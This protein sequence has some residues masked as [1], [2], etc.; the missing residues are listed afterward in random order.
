M[1]L[2]WEGFRTR[3]ADVGCAENLAWQ[4][5]SLDNGL[6][7]PSGQQPLDQILTGRIEGIYQASQ[8]TSG[9]A[10]VTAAGHLEDYSQ[11][12]SWREVLTHMATYGK[13]KEYRT[14]SAVPVMGKSL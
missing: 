4:V 12:S 10:V 9:A 6:S 8:K 11:V 13:E 7:Q 5:T 2:F 1:K 14:Y 3:V